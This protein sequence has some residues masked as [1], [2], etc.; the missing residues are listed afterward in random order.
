LNLNP[1]YSHL[2]DGGMLAKNHK[3][4][5]LLILGLFNVA[6]HASVL[7]EES[8][9][10][11]IQPGDVLEISVWKE[12]DLI[13]EVL[14]RPDGKFSFPLTGDVSGVGNS[15]PQLQ[16]TVQQR[17]TKW[18]S[19]P[20]V[21]VTVKNPAGNRIYVIGK[22]N[23]SGEYVLNRTVD[24]VQ[25]LSMAGGMAEFADSNDIRILRRVDNKLISFEFS[26]SDVVKGRNLEQNVI[27]LP[28]DTVVV[29]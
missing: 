22:V 8:T 6:F 17:L 10:Y 20:V 5:T 21:T 29:P 24:V 27:L 11:L 4:T 9:D 13:K 7:A 3:L 19:D 12:P 18:I 26:Y 25:A 15:V 14:V 16:E 1:F 2:R 28:G 23:K